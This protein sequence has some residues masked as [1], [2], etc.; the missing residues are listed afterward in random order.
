[1][2]IGKKKEIEINSVLD[3]LP[4]IDCDPAAQPEAVRNCGL[5]ACPVE[6]KPV[7]GNWT[8]SDWTEVCKYTTKPRPKLKPRSRFKP[9]PRSKLK[10]KSRLKTGSSN[11]GDLCYYS[12]ISK[13]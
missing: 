7:Y 12:T 8:T 1:V 9:R 3:E 10:P 5:K 13:I 4:E 2:P 11:S 6:Q